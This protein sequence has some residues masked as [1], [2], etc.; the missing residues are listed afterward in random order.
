MITKQEQQQFN[1]EYTRTDAFDLLLL[2]RSIDDHARGAG[3]VFLQGVSQQTI[4]YDGDLLRWAGP[5]VAYYILYLTNLCNV[6][7]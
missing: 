1:H 3:V 4:I 6:H 5:V 7:T 2:G